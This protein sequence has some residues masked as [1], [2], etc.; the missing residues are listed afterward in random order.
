MTKPLIALLVAT[1]FHAL[2]VKAVNTDSIRKDSVDVKEIRLT[3]DRNS[4]HPLNMSVGPVKAAFWGYAESTYSVESKDHKTTNEF[5]I[6]RIILMTEVDFRQITFFLMFDANTAKMHEYWAQ[7]AFMPEL[8]VRIGQMKQPFTM[9]SLMVPTMLSV[10]RMN[11]SV[12]YFAGIAGNPCYGNFVGRDKG[13]LITGDIL[14]HNN[15][16]LFNYSIGLF[17][18]AGMNQK[19]NNSQKDLVGML[20]YKPSAN[21]RLAT[22]FMLGTGHALVDNPYGAFATGDNYCRRRWS[23]GAE[24]KTRPVYLRSEWI[25]GNDGGIHGRGGY[26][27]AEVH[28]AKKLDLILDYDYLQ[29]NNA[30]ASSTTHTYTGGLQ[31]WLYKQ[32]RIQSE[33]SLTKQIQGPTSR[34]WITQFQ[35]AF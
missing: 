18:G 30:Q 22:S 26:A 13:I 3:T 2:P 16:Y 7:Y 4:P 24:I 14:K 19:E 31:Y 11:P 23:I 6:Q 33:F 12:A 9:E 8:K 35:L 20:D 21:V 17:N 28:L 25:Q 32:C 5:D 15:R 34:L 29:R 1:L 10:A 27:D